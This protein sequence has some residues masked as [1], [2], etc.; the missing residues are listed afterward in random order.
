LSDRTS[1]GQAIFCGLNWQKLTR[2]SHLL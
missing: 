2:T 1:F